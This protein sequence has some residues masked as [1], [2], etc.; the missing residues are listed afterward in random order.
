MT[1]D[2]LWRGMLAGI[3]AALLSTL[4][5]R[6]I[7]EP[8]VD[9]AIAYEA[10]HAAHDMG[11]GEEELV[12]RATQK[13]AGLLTALT[14]YGAAVGGIF[15]LVFAYGY[16]RIG[17]M[18][19]RSF[20]LLL[21][22]LAFLLVVI[23]PAIKYPQT[24]PAVGRHE[25][26]GVRT[27]AYFAMIVLSLGAAVIAGRLRMALSRSWRRID[28]VLLAIGAYLLLVMLGQYLL[29]T[30][31]EVPEHFPASLLW[32]FRVAAMATQL[33]LWATIGVAFGLSAERLLQRQ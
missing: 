8:Q 15:S 13:G 5:A 14:L 26:V 24:P 2:L 33:V 31:D 22:G 4:C 1:K 10:S 20:A 16:G 6:V 18:G 28:A 19:P 3:L 21:A 7:A 11:G 27:A 12:S 17:R 23:V 32:N 25:T 30:I 9:L 29:P